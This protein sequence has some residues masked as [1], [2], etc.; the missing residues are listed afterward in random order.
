MKSNKLANLILRFFIFSAITLNG[1]II[2]AQ[3]CTV[4]AG[5]DGQRCIE[6]SSGLLANPLLLSGNSAGNISNTPNLLWEIVSAPVGSNITFSTPNSN[7]TYVSGN[8]VDAPS[9]MYIFRLGMNCLSGE[10]VYDSVTYSINN[11]ADFDLYADKQWNQC[12]NVQTFVNLVGRPLKTGE[13]LKLNGRGIELTYSNFN[14]LLYTDIYGPTTDSVRFTITNKNYNTCTFEYY[15]LFSYKIASGQYCISF[16]KDAIINGIYSP[17]GYSKAAVRKTG[18]RNIDTIACINIG[19][20]F[21]SYANN[22][23][24]VGGRNDMTEY[25]GNF[26]TRTLSGS[27]TI[28]GTVLGTT[29]IYNIIQNRW[30]TVTPNTWHTYELNYNSNGC[31]ASF[32]DTVKVFFKSFSPSP[33]NFTF[34]SGTSYCLEP[35][36]FPLTS[37]K[38]PLVTTGVVPPNYTFN[39][40]IIAPSGASF[41]IS[42]STSK[43][44]LAIIGSNIIAGNYTIKTFITDTITLCSKPI[45][46]YFTISKKAILPVLRDTTICPSNLI[47]STFT[48]PYK[49]A[50]FGLPNIQ[51]TAYLISSTNLNSLFP[52]I[53]NDSTI[54]VQV[55]TTIPGYYDVVLL[56]FNNGCSDGRKDTFRVNLISSGYISNAGTDQ[57]LLCNVNSTSLAGSLPSSTGGNAGF[58]KF[59][60]AI[61]S[62]IGTPVVIADSANRNTLVSGFS[63]LSSYYFS[64]NVTGGNT[65]T[66]CALKPDTVLVIFSG[67][68]P[69]IPQSAQSDYA[70]CLAANGTYQLKSNAITPTFNVQWNKISGVGGSILNPNNQNTNVSGLTIGNYIFE[71]V[72]TNT[73]GVFKDTVNLNFGCVLPVK[74]VSFSG[75]KNNIGHDVLAWDISEEINMKHYELELSADA[76]KFTTLGIISVSNYT[77]TNKT[78]NYTNSS[79][80][81]PTNFYRLK[82]VDIDGSYT[83][84]NI[85]K[86]RN[87]KIDNADVEINPNPARSN[88]FVTITSLESKSST[89][90]IING[91][92]QIALKNS[93]S[94]RKGVN[95]ITID[96]SK[97]TRGVYFIRQ[98]NISKKLILE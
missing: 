29:S 48:I 93:Y 16:T 45:A 28:S 27:G 32:K 71:L 79:I 68:P 7:T 63:N 73:C 41:T 49:A 89:I 20:T 6:Y 47:G 13:V 36:A 85:I 35:S 75:F 23:C 55:N 97:L 70:G 64:W 58:W 57:M 46:S 18:T 2:K 86:I 84:S 12:A 38:F 33:T 8:A 3:N 19:S 51:Y 50:S 43:D 59:L 88:L 26:T 34:N 66:Y 53:L 94:L 40:T 56:P 67:I 61:S 54:S 69:S 4:N 15:P 98:N 60:P 21:L 5:I 92:G 72:V 11:I 82:M 74:L 37:F 83:Y 10:R 91:I 30:D 1:V 78:Y 87:T 90:E 76:N 9:G 65:S 22:I 96:V 25:N 14:A 52:T 42:N 44:S 80:F 77:S 39:S 17:L 95:T 31:Y 81:N 62:N 24:L